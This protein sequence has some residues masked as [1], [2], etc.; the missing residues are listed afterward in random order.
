MNYPFLGVTN[1]RSMD[2]GNTVDMNECAAVNLLHKSNN[3]PLAVGLLME[4][5]DPARDDLGSVEP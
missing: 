4:H 1:V 2:G 5:E 3:S